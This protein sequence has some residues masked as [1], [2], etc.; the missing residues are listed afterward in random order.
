MIKSNVFL[1]INTVAPDLLGWRPFT[2]KLCPFS[3]WWHFQQ[4]NTPITVHIN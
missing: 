2:I 1:K 3:C 4:G